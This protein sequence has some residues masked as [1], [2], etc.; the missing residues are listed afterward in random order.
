VS[1]FGIL[2]A[3]NLLHLDSLWNDFV[4]ISNLEPDPEYHE[5]RQKLK[6]EL[7]STAGQDA[8]HSVPDWPIKFLGC[9]DTVMGGADQIWGVNVKFRDQFPATGV[10]HVVH[11]M[12]MHD[13]RKD[14]ELKRFHLPRTWN[15]QHAFREIWLPGVHSDVG[16]GYAENF[17]SNIALLTMARLLEKHGGVA[18]Q[19][20]TITEVEHAIKVKARAGQIH[21]NREPSVRARQRR[22]DLIEAMDEIP[23]LH[24]YLLDKNIYF[25]DRSSVCGFRRSRPCIPI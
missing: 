17:I 9:F 22:I 7:K 11:P 24:H 6:D 12:S 19:K 1:D 23:P 20:E 18:L 15:H 3:K 10:Q 21:V 16:G 8:F 25:K 5:K 4:E 14:F 2:T 13:A